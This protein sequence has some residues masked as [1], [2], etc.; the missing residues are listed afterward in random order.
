MGT[1]VMY[2]PQNAAHARH[3]APMLEVAARHV[4]ERQTEDITGVKLP[5]S[6]KRP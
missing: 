6:R 1:W 3:L 2:R 5:R 4:A